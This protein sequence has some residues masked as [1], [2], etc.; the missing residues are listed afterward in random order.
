MS[1]VCWDGDDL[2]LE[3]RVQP[4]ASQDELVP[5]TDGVR[6]RLR[7][8]AVEGRANEAAIAW[9]ADACGVA[10]SRVALE[11]GARG[12]TKRFRIRAPTR[13]PPAFADALQ[14]SR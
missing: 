9:L 14:R 10:R 8:P 7:A 5:A 3:V 1:W 4:R 13:L 11:Q 6:L 2:V 12:R